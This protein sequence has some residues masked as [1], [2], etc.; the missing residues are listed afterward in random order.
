MK[1][2]L[3]QKID[4]AK[5]R[6]QHSEYI[7]LCTQNLTL[8]ERTHVLPFFGS[9]P[10]LCRL[11]AQYI[12]AIKN[13]DCFATEFKIYGDFVADLI[14]GDFVNGKYLLVEF[15]DGMPSSVF[16]PSAKTAPNWATRLEHAF[17][18]IVDWLWKLEDM[19][20][21]ND[22]EHVFGRR[23]VTFTGLIVIGKNMT[24]SAQEESRLK[25]RQDKVLIDSKGVSIIAYDDFLRDA[26]HWLTFIHRV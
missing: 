26:D 24:L 12:P 3:T 6:R 22:F 5:A 15:E 1:R 8:S 2:L 9:R 23:N 17:S 19:R 21:T 13:A 20:V 7:D 18:Q 4:A 25:W 14:V 16:T 10:D 11:F